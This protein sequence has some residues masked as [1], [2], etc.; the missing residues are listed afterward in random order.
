MSNSYINSKS[1]SFSFTD[2]KVVMGKVCDDLYAIKFRGFNQFKSNPLEINLWIE[3]LNFMVEYQ[4]IASFQITINYGNPLKEAAIQYD[5]K[6]DGTIK[7]DSASGKIDYYFF[8]DDSKLNLIV[9]P[10]GNPIVA[11]F[12]T[13]KGWTHPASYVDGSMENAGSYS[14]NDFGVNRYK[15]GSWGQ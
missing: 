1:S 13:E 7:V 2:A 3:I 8:P 15:K 9:T 6:D 11:K 12:L 4:D 10:K 14:K 5:F